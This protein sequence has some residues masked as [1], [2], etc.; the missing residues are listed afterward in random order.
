MSAALQ[1]YSSCDR[2]AGKNQVDGGMWNIAGRESSDPAFDR[3]LR[4]CLFQILSLGGSSADNIRFVGPQDYP[5]QRA[6]SKIK[7]TRQKTFLFSHCRNE[8]CRRNHVC[9][10]RLSNLS[11]LDDQSCRASTAAHRNFRVLRPWRGR[12]PAPILQGLNL[13]R[14]YGRAY[15]RLGSLGRSLLDQRFGLPPS[16][17]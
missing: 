13:G 7:G 10:R 4:P 16:R 8:Y 9:M 2:P 1:E 3:Q 15:S 14:S 6:V 12:A 17:V 11:C 5:T